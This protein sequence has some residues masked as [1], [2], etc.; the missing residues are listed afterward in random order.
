MVSLFRAIPDKKNIIHSLVGMGNGMPFMSA[1]YVIDTFYLYV[2]AVVYA[3]L[4]CNHGP[5][6]NETTECRNIGYS[7]LTR[8]LPLFDTSAFRG[9]EITTVSI[10]YHDT[11][12]N[13]GY[14]SPLQTSI[15]KHFNCNFPVEIQK[16]W[17]HLCH[18]I[19]LI[20]IWHIVD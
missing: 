13:W 5:C 11:R 2:V 12:F 18:G 8:Y 3:T 16:Y 1:I 9:N 15:F 10:C 20:H 19:R 17:R 6:Y 4:W 14:K 7:S